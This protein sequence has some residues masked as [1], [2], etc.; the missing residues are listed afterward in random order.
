MHI[1]TC[2][3]T[4][5]KVFYL[6]GLQMVVQDMLEGTVVA[7]AVFAEF[8]APA[9]VVAQPVAAVVAYCSCSCL[10]C[11]ASA[12]IAE[13]RS[14][15]AAHSVPGGCVLVTSAAVNE[16]EH[17]HFFKVFFDFLKRLVMSKQKEEKKLAYI[18]F[19]VLKEN[20]R[21]WK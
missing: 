14:V 5:Q 10:R 7:G 21:R 4:K 13:W 12:G 1:K 17:E 9:A 11:P 18:F 15:E 19:L 8:V 3:K 2:I 6:V 20:K 16:H